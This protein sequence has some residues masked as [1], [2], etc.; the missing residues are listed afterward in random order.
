MMTKPSIPHNELLRHIRGAIQVAI[1]SFT[2]RAFTVKFT[3]HAL[4][5]DN[6]GSDSPVI[7]FQASI[8]LQKKDAVAEVVSEEGA[9][10]TG[11]FL[12]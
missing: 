3:S 11:N 4:T 8:H 12:L 10:G 5:I 7:T 2:G 6:N 9:S 1:E